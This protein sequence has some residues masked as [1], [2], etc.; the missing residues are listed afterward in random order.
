M[1]KIL[2]TPRSFGKNNRKPIELLKE[3]GYEIIT[4][5]YQRIMTQ[6]EMSAAIRDVD[7]VIIGVDPL[8]GAVLKN[9]K[10]LKVISKYGVG[11]DNIDLSYAERQGIVV[12]KTLGANSN[13]VADF[14][15]ALMLATARRMVYIDQECRQRN[16]AKVSTIQMDNKTLGLIG[17]GGIAKAVVKKVSGFDMKIIAY[18]TSPDLE[19]AQ[20][21]NIAYVNLETL[22]QESDFISIH[23]PL[24]DSTKNLISNKEFALMKQTAVLVNTARG[25]IIDEAALLSALKNRR[26]WGAG[27]DVFEAEPPGN[28]EFLKLDNIIIGSHCAASTFEAIDA[29]GMMA[30]ENL[31]TSLETP[32]TDR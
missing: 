23:L 6:E 28:D 22:L 17:L 2:I 30:A 32:L 20:K 8:N 27:I 15:V 9:A 1:K 31:I 11:L 7:G 12:T 26:I 3:K 19:Y 18:D 21:H 14:A 13:A 16:W 24:L 25:G 29:M 5:P 4:N 10:Q